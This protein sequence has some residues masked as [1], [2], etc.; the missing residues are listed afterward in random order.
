MLLHAVCAA[1]V[2]W[3]ACMTILWAWA[4]DASG[5]SM[6]L[7]LAA[8]ML[9]IGAAA[10][11]ARRLGRAARWV[12]AQMR[13]SAAE[14]LAVVSGVAPGRRL[15]GRQLMRLVAAGAAAALL[16]GL[17]SMMAVRLSLPLTAY[18]G[19]RFVWTPLAWGILKFL[20]QFLGMLPMGAGVVAAF[21]AT[22]LVRRADRPG[23]AMP[24]LGDWLTAVAAGATV[25]AACWWL[26]VNLLLLLAAV[27]VALAALTRQTGSVMLPRVAAGLAAAVPIAAYAQLVAGAQLRHLDPA[28]PPGS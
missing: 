16:G 24:V 19:R 14:T 11:Q 20:V 7:T 21:G 15:A 1:L 22:A 2:V 8:T 26:G 28:T 23:Q 13:L 25:F 18:L 17:V 27:A 10:L 6:L 9:A 3:L 5:E 4:F 12:L